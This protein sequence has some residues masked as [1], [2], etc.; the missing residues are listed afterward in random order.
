[1]QTDMSTLFVDTCDNMN[2]QP[3]MS[4]NDKLLQLNT[5]IRQKGIN[6]L[7]KIFNNILCY[8]NELKYQ[9]L[10]VNVVNNK[11]N[12]CGVFIEVLISAGF[13]KTDSGH[14][15]QLKLVNN[16]LS[17]FDIYENK[18]A[19]QTDCNIAD[20]A[21]LMRLAKTMNQYKQSNNDNMDLLNVVNDFLY[22]MDEHNT[23]QEFEYIFN[24]LGKYCEIENCAMFRRNSRDKQMQQYNLDV[25]EIAIQQI[26]DKIHCYYA[27]CYDTRYRLSV[28]EQQQLTI[29]TT[30]DLKYKQELC[31]I[32]LS[33][34]KVSKTVVDNQRVNQRYNQFFAEHKTDDNNNQIYNFGYKFHYGYENEQAGTKIIYKTVLQKF[35]SLKEELTWNNLSI[36]S[37]SQFNAELKKANLHYQSSYRKRNKNWATISIQ[38]IVSLM[39]YCN[40]T[41]LQYCFSKTYRDDAY[42]NHSNF[43]FMGKYLKQAVNEFGTKIS[44]GTVKTFYHG[45]TEKL[46]FPKCIGFCSNIN[47]AIYINAPLSTSCSF[48]VA[49]NFCNNN[50]GLAIEFNAPKNKSTVKYFPCAWLSDYANESEYLFIQ[51]AEPLQIHHI[52]DADLLLQTQQNTSGNI[53]IK[54]SKKLTKS[55]IPKYI[56]EKYMNEQLR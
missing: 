11:L 48:A 42:Q 14:M 28:A 25:N 2:Q 46:L 49:V 22:L 32:L 10:D 9:S 24:V 33:K 39:V 5:Q 17:G 6:L 20:C 55:T 1:M 37:I 31:K 8:P 7:S 54:L 53:S 56:K 15:N 38:H 16:T 34:R 4:I 12:N 43:Y 18:N 26:F 40:F 27:H 47:H 30:D 29:P 3:T 21:S 19:I 36:V 35:N 13:Y 41:K 44:A 45:I 23:D 52:V 51:N 50:N